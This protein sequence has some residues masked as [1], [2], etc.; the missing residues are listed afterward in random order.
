VVAIALLLLLL[1]R[2]LLLLH[3]LHLLHL[4]RAEHHLGLRVVRHEVR[5]HRWHA[6]HERS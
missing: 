2:H 6:G 3:L 1:L 4:H 5:V